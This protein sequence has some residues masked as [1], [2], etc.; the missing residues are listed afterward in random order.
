MFVVDSEPSCSYQDAYDV[1]TP[2][3]ILEK[4]ANTNYSEPSRDDPGFILQGRRIVDIDSFLK[5]I[6]E[7][8]DHEPFHCS[9]KDMVPLR[10]VRKGLNSKIM[11]KCNMC[12][13]ESSVWLEPVDQVDSM[14]VNVA[15]VSGTLSTGGGHAQLEEITSTL[16]IPTMSCNTFKRYHDKLSVDWEKTASIEM[17]KAVRLEAEEAIKRGHV[18]ADGTPLLTVTA[19]GSW[20]KRSY[21]NQYN[22]MSGVVSYQIMFIFY[23]QFS[24]SNFFLG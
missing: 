15:A 23:T 14:D 11:F 17:E 9:F 24:F 8:D 6:R 1:I 18:A 13:I 12:N 20:A 21:R 10:E 22:S 4:D 7:M 5:Q 16:N 3:E 19:D 2:N